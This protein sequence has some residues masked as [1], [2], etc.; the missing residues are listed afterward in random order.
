ML[1]KKGKR[2][3]LSP[4]FEGFS[5]RSKRRKE[6]PGLFIGGPRKG[7]ENSQKEFSHL[8]AREREAKKESISSSLHLSKR[9]GR[10]GGRKT[11]GSRFRGHA[12]LFN[13]GE[14][15][16]KED[17]AYPPYQVE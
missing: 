10:K 17:A 12:C 16:G 13:N 11:I 2:E 14:K 4:Q 7:G 15:E 5:S 6:M 9:E 3:T 1:Q 8:I